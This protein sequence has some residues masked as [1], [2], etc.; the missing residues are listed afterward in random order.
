MT[1]VCGG[2]VLT[3]T[4]ICCVLLSLALGT[5]GIA[6]A[7][8]QIEPPIKKC[9]D[10]TPAAA[11][12]QLVEGA[13]TFS[14]FLFG[15]IDDSIDEPS[16][17]V[18]KLNI[19]APTGYVDRQIGFWAKPPASDRD[20]CVVRQAT[21]PCLG[22]FIVSSTPIMRHRLDTYVS[23]TNYVFS[24]CEH[25][26]MKAYFRVYVKWHRAVALTSSCVQEGY[27]MCREAL[28]ANRSI[29][30]E[31]EAPEGVKQLE[32]IGISAEMART[33]IQHIYLRIAGEIYRR[34]LNLSPSDRKD[35]G[36]RALNAFK[37]LVG[38]VD[39]TDDTRRIIADHRRIVEICEC[40]RDE[41]EC[42]PG[43]HSSISTSNRRKCGVLR[44][45]AL[46]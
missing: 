31:A 45:T 13:V 1:S 21:E 7:Q 8:G 25:E 43:L 42:V 6:V 15:S 33:Q 28:E 26:P 36:E 17:T 41:S 5:D 27:S 2:H 24:F 34:Y 22:G 19:R 16:F 14:Q 40:L 4:R 10:G 44:R 38:Q 35:D 20:L 30:K 23:F 11:S 39:S 29:L 37:K 12:V 46:R 18:T 32:A 9:E 3:N